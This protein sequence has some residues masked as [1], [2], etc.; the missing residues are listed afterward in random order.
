M[1]TRHPPIPRL[2]LMTDPRLGEGLWPALERL[3]RG[4]GVIFR[5]YQLPP[6]ERRALFARIAKVARRRGLV[7]LRAGPAPMRGEAGTHGRRGRGL[8]TWPVHSRREAVAAIR[9]GADALLVSPAFPTRS[10]PGAPA[11]G[12]LRFGLMVRGVDVPIIALGGMDRFRAK[13]LRSLKIHGWAAIDAWAHECQNGAM[14]GCRA[15]LPR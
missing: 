15:R 1:P 14:G 2:W 5:H 12:P 6:S 11:L 8:T 7:L 13:R 3:P 9:A 4:S 10:H